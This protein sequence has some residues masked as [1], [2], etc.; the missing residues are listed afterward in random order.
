MSK[1]PPL[2]YQ[3][4]VSDLQNELRIT[5]EQFE[6]LAKEND[7]PY[8]MVFGLAISSPKT[9]LTDAMVKSYFEQI[10]GAIS[11]FSNSEVV[12]LS[13]SIDSTPKAVTELNAK[14]QEMIKTLPK[15]T[16]F[17]LQLH[18]NVKKAI[19]TSQALQEPVKKLAEEAEKSKGLKVVS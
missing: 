19:E 7:Q 15:T 18:E 17:L 2:N 11:K 1:I 14:V 10:Q 6:I 12:S 13:L 16:P 3:S 9:G 4:T 8:T 5:K